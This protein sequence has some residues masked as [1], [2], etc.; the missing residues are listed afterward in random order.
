MK[1][2]ICRNS[3][4]SGFEENKEDSMDRL[5]AFEAML[6]DI[7]KQAAYE[8]EQMALLK[9]EGK[10]KTATYRQYFGNQ[11]LYKMMLEKYKQYGLI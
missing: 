8:K 2:H 10:E 3:A 7:Q 9:A 5:D 1:F 4:E 6:S 11:M